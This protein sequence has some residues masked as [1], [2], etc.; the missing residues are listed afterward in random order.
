MLGLTFSFNCDKIH[1]IVD[2]IN[3]ISKKDKKDEKPMEVGAWIS[4]DFA[5]PSDSATHLASYSPF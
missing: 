2:L 4:A 3:D 5:N 1:N